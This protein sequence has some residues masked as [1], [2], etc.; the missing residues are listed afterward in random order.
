MSEKDIKRLMDIAEDQLK[1]ALTREEALL[2]L[3]DAGILDEKGNFTAPYQNLARA[4]TL[5]RK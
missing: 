1:K 5:N 2:S 3:I 4:M